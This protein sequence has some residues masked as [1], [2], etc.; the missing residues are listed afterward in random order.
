MTEA[1]LDSGATGLVMSEEFARR[2][3]FKRTKLEKLV[4]VRNVDSMLN[5]AGPIVDTVKVEIFFKGHKERTEIDVIGR[6][7]WSVILGMLWLEHHNP[8]IDWKTG[9]VKMTRCP[10]ECGKK[11]RVEKQTKLGWKKQEEKEEKKERRKPM[12]GEEKT[13]A[14]I[15]EEKEKEEEDLIEL[16]VTDEVVEEKVAVFIDDVMIAMETKEGYDEIVEVVLRRLEENDLFVKPEK[17]VWKVR[18]VGFLEVIIG[19]DGVRMEKEKIQGV[20]EWPVPR[21]TK[22]MQKFL[23]LANYY[24]Q[25]VKDFARIAKLLHEMMRKETKWNWG[26]RQQRAFEGLKERFTTELVLVIP[27][28]DKERRVEVD[29]SDFVTGGVLS[30]KCEDEK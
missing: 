24:R 15:M 28:L 27:D 23:G 14:R 1:L 16:R 11:W 29:A 7:K 30:M 10:D 25:F 26:E 12:I 9:E 2:H 17:C 8:E 21:S 20:I 22:D 4:Y 18:E 19:E 3:K 13:I 6:Q 5:Y